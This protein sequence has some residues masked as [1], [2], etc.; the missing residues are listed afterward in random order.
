LLLAADVRKMPRHLESANRSRFALDITWAQA[1]AYATER[2][3]SAG[4]RS[5]YSS[6]SNSFKFFLCLGFFKRFSVMVRSGGGRPIPRRARRRASVPTLN[7]D[8][9]FLD[10]TSCDPAFS[11][12]NGISRR[13]AQSFYFLLT[14]C[15]LNRTAMHP[16]GKLAI[17]E[18]Q[19]PADIA[20]VRE[21]FVEYATWLGFSL[22]YQNFDEELASASRKVCRSSWPTA[23]GQ[24]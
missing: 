24:R 17:T 9:F 10:G 2:N 18:A 12:Q 1:E 19:S 6:T 14:H 22:A 16:T 20:A 11:G 4:D 23:A 15:K 21:L 8:C 5:S 13:F 3:A 7:F